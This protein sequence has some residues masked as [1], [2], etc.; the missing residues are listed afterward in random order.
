MKNVRMLLVGFAVAALAVACSQDSDEASTE[1]EEA[2]SVAEGDEAEEAAE[3]EEVEE[4]EEAGGGDELE[5]QGMEFM[6]SVA[7][8]GVEN[9]EDCD[10]V[11]AA[12]REL[13]DD[14]E[15]L[16]EQMTERAQT[17]GEEEQAAFEERY[18]ERLGTFMDQMTEVMTACGTHEE[19][20][21]L[22]EELSTQ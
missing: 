7:A 17:Q 18:A 9:V 3:V 6:E 8:A 10:A 2:P 12:W 11:A 16:L 14:N 15:D 19:V 5:E 20:P 22:L 1:T 4:V 13:I 21:G